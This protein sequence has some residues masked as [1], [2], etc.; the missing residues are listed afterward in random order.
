MI[1]KRPSDRAILGLII[2]AL[3]LVLIYSFIES[4][5]IKG[6]M[7][8]P[9][10]L[11]LV[12]HFFTGLP[13]VA[14]VFMTILLGVT[15]ATSGKMSGPLKI[16]QGVGAA[17][18]FFIILNGGMLNVSFTSGQVEARVVVGLFVSLIFLEASSI[19]RTLQGLYEYFQIRA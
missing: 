4:V 9:V 1:I 3:I 6:A 7:Q 5:S 17:I 18:Y 11:E 16:L 19:F 13:L 8:S 12:K 14:A 15:I 2:S 10:T